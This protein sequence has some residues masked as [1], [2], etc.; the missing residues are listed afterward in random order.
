MAASPAAAAAAPP[1]PSPAPIPAKK[2]SCSTQTLVAGAVPGRFYLAAKAC[3]LGV[4]QGRVA[5]GLIAARVRAVV[6]ATVEARAALAIAAVRD[7]AKG[8]VEAAVATTAAAALEEAVKVE[9]EGAE[10]VAVLEAKAKE[11]ERLLAAAVDAFAAANAASE[12][13]VIDLKR[14]AEE[15]EARLIGRWQE[16]LDTSEATRGAVEVGGTYRNMVL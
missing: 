12:E 2:E 7:K 10:R 5:A 1:R 8:R 15:R 14:L 16:R 4:R 6:V 3:S 11:A 9:A 13:E